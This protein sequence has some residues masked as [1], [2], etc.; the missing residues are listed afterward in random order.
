MTQ[1][2]SRHV[3]ELSIQTRARI[4]ISYHFTNVSRPA[5][6][7]SSLLFPRRWTLTSQTSLPFER[8]TS[9]PSSAL[10]LPMLLREHYFISSWQANIMCNL[11]LMYHQLGTPTQYTIPTMAALPTIRARDWTTA[12]KPVTSHQITRLITPPWGRGT[13][14]SKGR[15]RA[16]SRTFTQ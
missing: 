3:H 8:D 7:A 11:L 5:K 16:A 9:R 4:T 14:Q 10:L 2:S 15:P 6:S 13:E 12:S 1:Y